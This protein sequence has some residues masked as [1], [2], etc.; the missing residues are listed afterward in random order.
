MIALI[1]M[2]TEIDVRGALTSIAVPTLIVHRD[3]DAIAPI[4]GARYMTAQIPGARLVELVGEHSPLTG[5]TDAILNEI[6]EFVSG[7][8]H[9]RAS[10]RVLA[11]VMFTDIVSS[12]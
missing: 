3:G 8:R 9:Q 1:R 6:E 7:Q 12:T 5:D 4:E 11:T 10:D 2:L